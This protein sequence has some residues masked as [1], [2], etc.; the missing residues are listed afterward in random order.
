ME[1]VTVNSLKPF[2]ILAVLAFIGYSVY[3]RVNVDPDDLP[4]E[5][6]V[7]WEVPVDVQLGSSDEAPTTTPNGDP[8][9]PQ[10]S[11]A[12]S[13][14]QSSAVAELP[15]APPNDFAQQARGRGYIPET[16]P[17]NSSDISQNFAAP[18][19]NTLPTSP[20]QDDR[21]GWSSQSPEA[22][23]VVDPRSFAGQLPR[24]QQNLD[25]GRMKEGLAALSAF[26]FDAQLAPSERQQLNAL[27]DQVA[28]SVVYSMQHHLEPPHVVAAGERLED[29]AQKYNIPWRLLANIN[30]I[31]DPT[32]LQP[33]EQLKVMRGP[34]NAV[35][36]VEKRELTLWIGGNY[37][38]RFPVGFGQRWPAREGDFRVGKKI[39]NPDFHGMGKDFKGDDP[40]NPFGG[41]WIT[42]EDPSN[43]SEPIG[44]QGTNE[45]QYVGRSDLPGGITLGGR[46]IADVYGILSIGSRVTIRK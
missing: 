34:F 12:E 44:I 15:S 38:G 11:F 5:V 3:C 20:A 23:P 6:A 25:C 24:I 40:S 8:V 32:A 43:P 4:E 42:L 31:S 7:G 13:H 9:T 19:S 39:L 36:S 27:L 41:Y 14:T 30:G 35:L 37:A 46:D 2:L 26:Y 17:P 22:V 16:T 45:Q 28:G 1:D 10:R 21:V 18:P 29:I 33:G